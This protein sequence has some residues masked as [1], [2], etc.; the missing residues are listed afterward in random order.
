VPNRTIEDQLREEYFLLLPAMA[1]AAEQLKTQIQYTLLPIA[2]HLKKHE[3][4]IVKSRIKE[5]SSAMDA[6]RRRKDNN[7]G[8][9]FDVDHPEIYSLLSLRDLVG[10]RVLAFPS[11]RTVEIDA[12]LR[13]QFPDWTSDPIIDAGQQLAFKYYGRCAEASEHVLCE[14]QIV[15]MLT[16]L[17][18]EVEHSAIYKPAPNFKGIASSLLMRDRR[19]EVYRA[20]AGFE[21]EFE[22]QI[23]IAESIEIPRT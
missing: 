20:L 14:Y 21:E 22:R 19:S 4:L 12:L 13:A 8:R 2:R 5:C 9:L 16:G 10:V 7:E 1:R 17:F 18:W 15:P 3:N 23:Q 6:L 11:S